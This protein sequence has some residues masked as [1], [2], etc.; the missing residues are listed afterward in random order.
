M[1]SV[2]KAETAEVRNRGDSS[3]GSRYQCERGNSQSGVTLA[4][5]SLRKRGKSHV[6]SHTYRDTTAFR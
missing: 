1:G 2:Y 3:V 5:E 6:K 4:W